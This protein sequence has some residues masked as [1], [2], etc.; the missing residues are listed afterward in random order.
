[1]DRLNRN[2]KLLNKYR[3]NKMKQR[4]PYSMRN[5]PKSLSQKSIQRISDNKTPK[6]QPIRFDNSPQ[7][8]RYT[9]SPKSP[10]LSPNSPSGLIHNNN[11]IKTPSLFK[12]TPKLGSPLNY[13]DDKLPSYNDNSSTPS[14]SKKLVGLTPP[15]NIQSSPTPTPR[16]E[17]N[18][19]K[20]KTDTDTKT[21]SE[22]LS[23]LKTSPDEKSKKSTLSHIKGNVNNVYKNVKDFFGGKKT[24]KYKHK[25]DKKSKKSKHKTQ[26]HKH[27]NKKHSKK[28]NKKHNK[29][30]RKHR[31]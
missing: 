17:I 23:K 24:R 25:K 10:K 18:T 21:K 12:D 15:K 1:M 5:S 19:P 8:K 27:S 13:A 6:I 9:P 11:D 14:S 3:P 22:L 26:K 2:S 30:S 31:K 20:P 28:H 7:K 16:L 29:K 4:D